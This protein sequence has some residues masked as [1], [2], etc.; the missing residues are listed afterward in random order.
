[1][2]ADCDLRSALFIKADLRNAFLDADFRNAEFQEADLTDAIIFESS[3][4]QGALYDDETK[5]PEG[6]MR[7]RVERRT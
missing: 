1:V 3:R 6:S 4:F 5:W 7:R 2:V